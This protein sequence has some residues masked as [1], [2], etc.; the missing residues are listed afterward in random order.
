[1]W[2]CSR[3]LAVTA[4][5][6]M[7]AKTTPR[8]VELAPAVMRDGV[9]RPAVLGLG[10]R[11]VAALEEMSTAELLLEEITALRLAQHLVRGLLQGGGGC[12]PRAIRVL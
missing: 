11:Q 6:D 9:Q 8:T 12:H 2:S 4:A 3:R 5:V 7:A 10:W 1:M